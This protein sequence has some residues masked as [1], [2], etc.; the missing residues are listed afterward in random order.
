MA[1]KITQITEL[2]EQDRYE[3]LQSKICELKTKNENIS[4]M[5]QAKKTE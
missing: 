2:I 1:E 3:S 5:L 4:K